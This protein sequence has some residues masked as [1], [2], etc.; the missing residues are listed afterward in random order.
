MEEMEEPLY[1]E[2]R[3]FV[4]RF[5]DASICFLEAAAIL[6]PMAEQSIGSSVGGP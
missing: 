6:A 1:I 5:I 4:V 2:R 3:S